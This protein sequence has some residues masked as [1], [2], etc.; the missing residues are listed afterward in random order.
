MSKKF[1]IDIEAFAK[2]LQ[3]GQGLH[4]QDGLLTPLIKQIT[5]AAL[6]SEQDEHLSDKDKP[7]RKNGKSSKT[8]KTSTGEFDLET[9]RDRNGSFE[10]QTVKKYQTRLTDEMAV[11]YTHL[12]AH[13]T[14]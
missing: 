6:N 2:G 11:S 5:E 12:R 1:E 9:P 8:I 3:S 13:E 7:N 14:V 10:P 4:G